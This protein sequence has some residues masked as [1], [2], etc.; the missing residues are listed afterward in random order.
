MKE[1]SL[2]ELRANAFFCFL[3]Q[4]IS[5]PV[6]EIAREADEWAS[7]YVVGGL[8]WS[9]AEKPKTDTKTRPEP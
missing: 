3:M 6:D 5:A 1:D 8:T 4:D 2:D 9:G 7:A